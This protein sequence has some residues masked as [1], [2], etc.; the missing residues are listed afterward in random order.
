MA[1]NQ[2]GRIA[3]PPL[4]RQSKKLMRRIKE[5]YADAASEKHSPKSCTKHPAQLI[6]ILYSETQHLYREADYGRNEYPP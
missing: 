5:I 6:K 2:Q 4:F 1:G 3:R